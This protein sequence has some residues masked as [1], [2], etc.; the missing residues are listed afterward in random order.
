[1]AV[2]CVSFDAVGQ[3]TSTAGGVPKSRLEFVHRL[4]EDS[5]GSRQVEA[6]KVP[7][8]LER[9]QRARALYQRAVEAERAGK[10]KE[11]K[12]LVLQA[13]RAILEAV[14]LAGNSDEVGDKRREDLKARMESVD[15]LLAAHERI[16]REKKSGDAAAKLRERVRSLLQQARAARD[17]GSIEA[18]RTLADEAYVATKTSI[19]GLRSGDTLIRSLD[20]SSKEAEYAYEVDRNDTHNMLVTVLLKEKMDDRDVARMVRQHVALANETRKRAESAAERG[21]FEGAIKTMEAATSEL[22][23]AIRRA[24]IYI[25]G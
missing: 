11:V 5:T 10:T 18:A 22:V 8:A 6:S 4:I 25:P 2:G 17:Q 20:F 24:G 19:E 16:T 7:A 12:A 21:E 14:K 1:M 23:K 13:T 3:T 9:R 15:A